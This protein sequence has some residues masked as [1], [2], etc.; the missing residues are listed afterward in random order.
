MLMTTR[1]HLGDYEFSFDLTF[2]ICQLFIPLSFPM[3]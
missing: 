3:V 2:V 1:C